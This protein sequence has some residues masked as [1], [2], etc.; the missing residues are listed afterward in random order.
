MHHARPSVVQPQRRESG[1]ASKAPTPQSQNSH[2][3]TFLIDLCAGGWRFWSSSSED[4]K[5]GSLELLRGGSCIRQTHIARQCRLYIYIYVCIIYIY[6]FP[7]I[8]FIYTCMIH[9]YIY[10]YTLL[11]IQYKPV[12]ASAY[13]MC[14]GADVTDAPTEEGHGGSVLWS[15]QYLTVYPAQIEP[16][17]GRN[18][19]LGTAMFSVHVNRFSICI[20]IAVSHKPAKPAQVNRS[21]IQQMAMF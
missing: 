4:W 5:K 1:Q 21:K 3:F 2:E 11:N 8:I 10:I 20:S 9:L 15:M 12:E 14:A 17:I 13:N 6:A 18:V 16:S 7:L 19:G